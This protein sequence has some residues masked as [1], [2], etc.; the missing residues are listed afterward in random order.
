LTIPFHQ[1]PK[2]PTN[3]PLFFDRVGSCPY[4]NGIAGTETGGPFWVR[5]DVFV[6]VGDL[7]LQV[8][9]GGVWAFCN[10]PYSLDMTA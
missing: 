9:A 3:R 7:G 2:F 5:W 6:K 1:Q 10:N 8:Q 4:P